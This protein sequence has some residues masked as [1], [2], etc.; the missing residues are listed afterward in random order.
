MLEAAVAVGW[1]P[2]I[3]LDALIDETALYYRM[4]EDARDAE[5]APLDAGAR[6]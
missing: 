6:V 5:A 3:D 4:R 2:R 1:E